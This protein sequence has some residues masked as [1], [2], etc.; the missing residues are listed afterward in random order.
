MVLS[1]SN[2]KIIHA[3]TKRLSTI[4]A[5]IGEAQA[6][7]LASQIASS[8][9][10]YSL[11]LEGDAINIILAIQQL[12]LSETGILLPLFLIFRFTC[13]L[14]IAGRLLKSLEVPI[15]MHIV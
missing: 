2:G 15:F 5:S 7:L 9:G 10:I 12:D 11:I 1:D 4:D 8:L 3:T 14:C 13:Y 6:A